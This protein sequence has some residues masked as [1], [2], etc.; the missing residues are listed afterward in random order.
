[1]IEQ[2]RQALDHLDQ[3]PQRDQEELAQIIEEMWE[4]SQVPP[5]D[6]AKVPQEAS[7]FDA[8]MAALDVIRGKMSK[9]AVSH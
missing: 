9:H 6:P 4:T 3:L 1:M 7:D 8:D 5:F 2:L